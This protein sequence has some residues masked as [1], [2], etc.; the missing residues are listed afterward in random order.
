MVV[1]VPHTKLFS[2]PPSYFTS[3]RFP[4][5]MLMLLILFYILSSI[6]YDNIKIVSSNP[7]SSFVFFLMN[8]EHCLQSRLTNDKYP[9]FLSQKVFTSL[10]FKNNSAWYRILYNF[11]SF[12]F[13]QF[14]LIY[15][16]LAALGLCC[17]VLAFS[18]WVEQGLLF[19]CSAQASHWGGFS[20]CK[21]Q[22][23][24]HKGL[25]A[26]RHVGSSGPGIKLCPL[27]WQADS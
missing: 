18:S 13:F 4:L 3:T 22:A 20:Y 11:F 21:A 19:S 16:F 24:G 9:E 27:H 26:L 15:L 12:F 2:I 14:F 25:V 5:T 8:F 17:C 23:L 10:F 6:I 7:L 1:Q